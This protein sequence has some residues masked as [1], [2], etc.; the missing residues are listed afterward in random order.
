MPFRRETQNLIMRELERGDLPI[1]NEWRNDPDVMHFLGNNF[2]F[3]SSD[4]D[5][6]WFDQYLKHRDR[7]VRLAMIH[8]KDGR[9]LGNVNLTNIHPINRAAEFS[10]VIG[11]KEYW[12][13]GF[14]EEATRV[15]LD[16]GFLNLNLHRIYLSVIAYNDRALKLYE[17]IGFRNEG[18]ARE[19]IYKDGAFHDVVNMGILKK[20]YR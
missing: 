3:I 10:I 13:H 16:H 8:K 1:L 12:G 4:V 9:Y 11:N 17:K 15:M 2:L 19:G 6:A 5:E 20:E 14:G 7:N 18:A